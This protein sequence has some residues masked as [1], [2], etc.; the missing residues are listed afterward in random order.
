MSLPASPMETEALQKK[1]E[2]LS[3]DKEL[4]KKTAEKTLAELA[5]VYQVLNSSYEAL[6]RLERQHT[7]TEE[8]HRELTDKLERQ[9]RQMPICRGS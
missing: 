8:A 4:M 5:G 6:S 1:L 7:S 2:G 9:A 3:H